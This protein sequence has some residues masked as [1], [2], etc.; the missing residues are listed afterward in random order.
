MNFRPAKVLNAFIVDGQIAFDLLTFQEVKNKYATEFMQR[1]SELGFH[2]IHTG[3]SGDGGK[4][5][6]NLIA[7][8]WPIEQKP[9]G[10]SN[11]PPFPCLIGRAHVSIGTNEGVDILT[12]HA[13]NGSNNGWDKIHTLEAVQ[14]V[15]RSISPGPVIVTGDYNEPQFFPGKLP[16]RSWAW[17]SEKSWA[18]RRDELMTR[19]NA[20]G[21]MEGHPRQRWDNAVGWFFD[22]GALHD[23]QHAF[24]AKYGTGAME[25]TYLTRSAS[26]PERW[27]DHAFISSHF[28]VIE[29][30]YRHD[31]RRPGGESDHSALC[32]ELA[33][34]PPN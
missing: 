27:F 33:F 4:T 16:V 11:P 3:D 29:C 31:V 21:G 26:R 5:Y 32:I 9:L 25:A 13:P 1:L 6:G 20:R 8:R 10:L 2:A 23:L 15:I 22:D 34:R 24:W 14:R 19:E 18:S 12:V 28:E 7:S 17:T 30:A